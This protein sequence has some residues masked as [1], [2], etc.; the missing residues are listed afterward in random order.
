MKTVL[1]SAEIDRL[2]FDPQVGDA[3]ERAAEGMSDNARDL[4]PGGAHSRAARE[5]IVTEL[6]L[7]PQ[8]YESRCGHAAD[9]Y[10][11]WLARLEFGTRYHRPQPHLRP[12]STMPVNI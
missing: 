2:A 7:T 9:E 10:G 1:N 3:L 5:G 6:E 11:F 8:G 12:A 4:A